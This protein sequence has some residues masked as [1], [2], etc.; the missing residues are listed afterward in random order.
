[1]EIEYNERVYLINNPVGDICGWIMR[2]NK[3]MDVLS[4]SILNSS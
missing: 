3:I 4:L 1:M 2:L